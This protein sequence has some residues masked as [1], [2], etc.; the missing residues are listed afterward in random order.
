VHESVRVK[1]GE[2]GESPNERRL[3]KMHQPNNEG[4]K[5]KR[6][7]GRGEGWAHPKEGAGYPLFD[8]GAARLYPLVSYTAESGESKSAHAYRVREENNETSSRGNRDEKEKI[9]SG[10]PSSRFAKQVFH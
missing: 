10:Q 7:G 1:T 8:K 4:E 5:Q 3:W 6:G 2:G 9:A